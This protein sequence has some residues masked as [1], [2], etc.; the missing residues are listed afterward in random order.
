MSEENKD[1][2]NNDNNNS[3]VILIYDDNNKDFSELSSNSKNAFIMEE[4]KNKSS[5]KNQTPLIIVANEQKEEENINNEKTNDI[6]PA[7][8]IIKKINSSSNKKSSEKNFKENLNTFET[9]KLYMNKNIL[10][11]EPMHL[12]IYEREKKNISRKNNSIKKKKELKIQQQISNLKNPILN[13]IS[14]NILSQH[15][16]YVPIQ[17]RAGLIHNLHQLHIILNEKKNEAKKIEKENEEVLEIKNYKKNK[18]SFNERDWNNFIENQD[19]WNKQKY[20]KKKAIELMREKIE[21]KVNH[22]PKINRNS[23]K[24]VNNIRKNKENEEDIYD[25]LYNDFNFLQEKKKLK[26]CNSM[27]SFKPIINKGIKKNMFKNSISNNNNNFYNNKNIEKQIESI[28][29]KKIKNIKKNNNKLNNDKLENQTFVNKLSNININ[30]DSK[31]KKDINN[32][33]NNKIIKDS[34]VYKKMMNK[35]LAKKN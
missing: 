25:K 29:Q 20:L 30:L 21:V 12:N 13:E 32:K 5:K 9:K 26:I 10:K 3:E 1:N 6:Q 17:E 4:N 23:K 16:D 33:N 28:I 27:P 2:N 14:K 24:I 22:K 35:K 8:R 31:Q 19:Y 34:Y 7:Q 15:G 11:I 18:K